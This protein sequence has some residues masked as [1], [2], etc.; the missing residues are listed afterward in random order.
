MYFPVY[1]KRKTGATPASVPDL[2]TGTDPLPVFSTNF[3]NDGKWPDALLSSK[4]NGIGNP[5][6]RVAVGYQFDDGADGTSVDLA[7]TLWAFDHNSGHWYQADSGTLKQGQLTYLKAPYLADPPPTH[8][9]QLKPTPG[10]QEL[11]IVVA[12]PGMSAVD[13]T[14]HFVAGPDL[15]D[16]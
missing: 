13:G 7:V 9:N 11:L 5:I 14:Y 12:D 6:K 10:G 1:F 2:G 3:G 8:Q 4:T 15:S 16:F